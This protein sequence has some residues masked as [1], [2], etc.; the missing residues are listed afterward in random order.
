[1]S[2]Q[3]EEIADVIQYRAEKCWDCVFFN[4]PYCFYYGRHFDYSK[5]ECVTKPVWC[6]VERIIVEFGG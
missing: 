2:G 4:E 3:I 6:R 5:D 1:M